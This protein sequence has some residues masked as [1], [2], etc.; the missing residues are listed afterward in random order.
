[1]NDN[2]R[3]VYIEVFGLFGSLDHK[4]NLTPSG[5]TIIHGPNGCG[6]TTVLRL[7]T[8]LINKELGVLKETRFK[9]I[10]LGFSDNT[11]LQLI[12]SEES[13]ATDHVLRNT[14]Q[15]L[16]DNYSSSVNALPLEIEQQHIVFKL[17]LFSANETLIESNDLKSTNV[18]SIA[19]RILT[20]PEFVQ[21]AIPQISQ[22]G[23]R[24]WRDRRTGARLSL[25]E[26][27]TMFRD[28]L[29]DAPEWFSKLVE[30][31][32]LGFINAQR[33]LDISGAPQSP[34]DDS[35]IPVRE[36]VRVYSDD[37][38]E[39]INE[40][41]RTSAV[42]SQKRERTF[43]QRILQKEYDNVKDPQV[44]A[45]YVELQERFSK[46][47]ETGLQEEVTKIDLP[48][49]KLNPTERRVL[50]LYLDDLNEK[51]NVF[52]ELQSQIDAFRT[53]VGKKFRRKIFSIDRDNGFVIRDEYDK[54]LLSPSALSSGEQHQIVMFYDL[55]F[56]EKNNLLFLIDEPE[57]SL[58]VG[59]QRQFLPDLE[60][61]AKLKGH[62]FLVATHSPQVIGG[63]RELAV[64]LDGGI[65]VEESVEANQMAE[66]PGK[67][68]A[69]KSETNK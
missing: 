57:I 43:P 15:S 49:G 21:K 18:E 19:N 38:R 9:N 41:L 4:I 1:M 46:L 59:W 55:I 58:H 30:P 68:F 42:I 26:V 3:I 60:I 54:S 22:I 48:P 63:R 50:S 28:V 31:I 29:I 2:F 8:A 66:Q 7:I 40:T 37:I 24:A 17:S 5:I 61:V 64:A 52:S 53:I 20:D 13:A 65:Q 23:T 6:K 47:A 39:R 10:N 27:I 45:G 33:L 69:I 51:L 12:R 14:N 36:F 67:Q 25:S 34:R 56:S 11:R 16:F 62:Q 32:S 35:G 44:R